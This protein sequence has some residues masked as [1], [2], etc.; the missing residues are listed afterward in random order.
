MRVLIAGGYGVFGGR[1]AQLLADEP[2]LT[3]LIAGRS[4]AK[5]LAFCR[6]M[7]GSTAKLEP[8]VFD[9]E[10]DLAASFEA[11]K[12]DVI[13]DATGPF[14]NYSGDPYRLVRAAVERGLPYL[15]LADGAAFVA[16]IV[17]FD[18]AA[19][20]RGIAVLSGVSSFPVLTAAVV[21]HLS[22]DGLKVESVTGG[23]APSPYAGVGENVICAIATYAGKP[24]M[25]LRDG[26]R[27]SGTGL[28]DLW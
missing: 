11:L 5:A 23:I 8:A 12:P 2:R 25:L 13:V 6:G 28:V 3:L 26:Q 16:G 4:P 9:R 10:G 19:K 18:A 20:A 21:R 7:A 24:V 17:Q 14:Q 15:D 27:A 22:A 1:I